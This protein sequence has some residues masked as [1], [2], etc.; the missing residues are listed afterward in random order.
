MLSALLRQLCLMIGIST[1]RR[2]ERDVPLASLLTSSMMARKRSMRADP[3]I[4]ERMQE[5]KALRAALRGWRE[6]GF[7]V[8]VSGRDLEIDIC[9]R[10]SAEV[11][12]EFSGAYTIEI[13]MDAARFGG[14]DTENIII[15]SRDV[16]KCA[17]LPPQAPG[18]QSKHVTNN[19]H[20]SRVF[21]CFVTASFH[22]IPM[23]PNGPQWFPMV[24]NGCPRF[25]K[26][27]PSLYNS[28]L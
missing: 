7:D 4:R 13:A 17:Y 26:I 10:Y 21:M 19:P 12:R 25:P 6:D 11:L 2:A 18:H 5:K 24:P 27:C 14:V 8:G 23:A 16:G 9:C 28:H 15:Y 1:T 20:T 22:V 3:A